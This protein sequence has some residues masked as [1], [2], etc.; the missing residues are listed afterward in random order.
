MTQD[1][2]I[3]E[4]FQSH[5]GQMTLHQMHSYSWYGEFRAR[6]RDINRDDPDWSLRFAKR[7]ETPS[8]NIY[9]LE[10]KAKPGELL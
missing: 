9:V 5:A 1:Q 6:K 4:A 10:R 7:G 8:E 2:Q 3:I